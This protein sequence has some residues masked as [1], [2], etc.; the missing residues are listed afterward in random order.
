MFGAVQSGGRGGSEGRGGVG[1]HTRNRF[2][3]AVIVPDVRTGGK[4]M[5]T[6]HVKV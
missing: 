2:I 6:L 1:L 5:G 4:R 3:L